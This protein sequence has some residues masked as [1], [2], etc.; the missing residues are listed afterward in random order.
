[1]DGQTGILVDP[2]DSVAL[3]EAI[4]RMLADPQRAAEMGAA[5]RARA[6]QTFSI[7]RAVDELES[8]YATLG[9][10]NKT[11]RPKKEKNR[12]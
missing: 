8:L 9:R 6:V 3:G 5:G 11:R 1:V 4:L 12:R 7:G 2:G 10:A